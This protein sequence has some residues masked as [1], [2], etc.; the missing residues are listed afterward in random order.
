MTPITIKTDGVEFTISA[1]G[2]ALDKKRINDLIFG[3]REKT[4]DSVDR[5]LRDPS[6]PAPCKVLTNDSGAVTKRWW[7]YAD[8]LRWFITHKETDGIEQMADAVMATLE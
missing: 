7:F 6:F 5:F 8:V 4:S 1:D 2:L 3:K